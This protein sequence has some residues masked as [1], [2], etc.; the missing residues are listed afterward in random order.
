MEYLK[1][2]ACVLKLDLNKKITNFSDV[3]GSLFTQNGL[4]KYISDLGSYF[5]ITNDMYY[6]AGNLVSY[7]TYYFRGDTTNIYVMDANDNEINAIIYER[8]TSNNKNTL[9][10]IR[11]VYENDEWLIDNISILSNE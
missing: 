11:I 7:Q 8:W 3:V 1:K 9:A 6:L 4:N 10:T 2:L 5:A